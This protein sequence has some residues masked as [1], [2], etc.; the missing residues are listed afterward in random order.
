MTDNTTRN[1]YSD[2]SRFQ[3]LCTKSL[4]MRLDPLGVQPGYLA[5]LIRLWEQDDITQK[6]LSETMDIEQATLSNTLKRMERD[7]LISR[8]PNSKD[9]RRHMIRLTDHG[10]RLE[11]PVHEALDDL[12]LLVNQGLTVNDLR[13]FNRIMKQMMEHLENDQAEPLFVL[14]DE[15]TD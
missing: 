11:K 13:Y 12:R 14:L 2:I 7:Q 1:I 8:Q 3:R 15:M 6:A 10:R 4:C 5:V 9:R